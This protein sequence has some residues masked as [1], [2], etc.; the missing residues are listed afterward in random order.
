M[1]GAPAR[2]GIRFDDGA[3]YES[4][5]GGWSRVVGAQFLNWLAPPLQARWLEIGCGTGAFTQLIG[6]RCRPAAIVA[7]DPAAAQIA[8]ARRRLTVDRVTFRIGAAE[9]LPC[10]DASY[11][12]VVSALAI[13]FMS[14]GAV[15]M[16]E[17]RRVACKG[18]TIAG[19]VWDFAGGRTP[20]APLLRALHHLNIETPA[21]PGG[22]DCTIPA[23][24]SLFARAGLAEIETSTLDIEV[25]FADFE[26]FW[27]AQ[28]PSFSPVTRR[29]A[30]LDDAQRARLVETL[31]AKLPVRPDGRIAY[32]A[33]THA[34]KA[35]V[36]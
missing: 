20:H 13:N 19:Y 30:G 33:R 1:T 21:P 26:A 28:T 17:M 36:P 14:D 32:E 18:G 31:S 5:M 29:I 7:V 4:F 3:A 12:F 9:A 22:N 25:S 11:D 27:T 6:E 35:R 8:Y 16:R 15:A 34:V 23:L 24:R 2:G 10:Q